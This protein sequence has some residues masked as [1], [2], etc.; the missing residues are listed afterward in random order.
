VYD[1]TGRIT[2]TLVD[3]VVPAG[4]YSAELDTRGMHAGVYFCELNAGNLQRIRRLIVAH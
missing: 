1:I 3:R 4:R 2:A